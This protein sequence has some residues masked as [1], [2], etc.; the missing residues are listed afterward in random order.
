MFTAPLTDP[1][2]AELIGEAKNIPDGLCIPVKA[3]SERN[4]HWRKGYEIECDSGN[5]FVVKIRLSSVN[6]MDFSAILGYRLPGLYT[7]FRLRRY[8]GRHYHSNTL[9]NERFYDFHVHTATERYQR[10]GFH[11]DTFAEKTNRFYNLES[12]IQCLVNECGFRS[13]LA[14][15][16]LFKNV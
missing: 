3:M 7:I 10:P 8:N 14:D 5:C 11:E 13:P 16:P 9:E 4:G 6:P 12:A 15:S 2:I 1:A